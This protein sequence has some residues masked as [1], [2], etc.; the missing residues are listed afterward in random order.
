MSANGARPQGQSHEGGLK[1]IVGR[2]RIAQHA[3]A[4][5]EHHAAVATHKLGKR[6]LIAI[7]REAFQKVLIEYLAR[8]VLN[9]ELANVL[10][11]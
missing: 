7:G 6:G 3:T 11:D 8:C 2:V 9:S 5:A 1:S 4:N 10:E